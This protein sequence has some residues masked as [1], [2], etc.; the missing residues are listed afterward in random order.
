MPGREALVHQ[1][2]LDPAVVLVQ[3]RAEAVPAHEVLDRVEAEVGQLGDR[4]ADGR[5]VAAGRPRDRA[6]AAC[7]PP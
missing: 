6:A 7:R 5:A 4:L 3:Q 1:Q 2:R